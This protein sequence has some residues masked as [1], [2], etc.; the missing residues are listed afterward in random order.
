MASPSTNRAP[1]DKLLVDGEAQLAR[2]DNWDHLS[3]VEQ[4]E[5]TAGRSIYLDFSA[6]KDEDWSETSLTKM[7]LE[8]YVGDDFRARPI[9][10]SP[11]MHYTIGGIRV[12]VEGETGIPGVYAPP[13][14]APAGNT[15]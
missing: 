2:F 11:I 10:V 7:Y 1:G 9:K 14:P 5:F 12:D 3:V 13:P 15:A 6:T 4:A 8:K